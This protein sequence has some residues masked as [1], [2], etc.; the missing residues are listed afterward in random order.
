MTHDQQ[1]N[2]IQLSELFELNK[3]MVLTKEEYE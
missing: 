2:F 1:I 3:S